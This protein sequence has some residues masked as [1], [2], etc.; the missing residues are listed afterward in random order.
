MYRERQRQK[1]EALQK[2]KS[3]IA[4]AVDSLQAATHENQQLEAENQKLSEQLRQLNTSNGITYIQP[5]TPSSTSES[6]YSGDSD[7]GSSSRSVFPTRVGQKIAATSAHK[8]EY[9]QTE[10]KWFE[11]ACFPLLFGS[12]SLHMCCHACLSCT[13]GGKLIPSYSVY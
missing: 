4:Q 2:R 3:E 10:Q 12:I 11:K 7:S 9:Q 8:T 6:S 1:L 13:L 5:S